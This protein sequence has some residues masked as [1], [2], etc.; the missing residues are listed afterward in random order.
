MSKRFSMT[1]AVLAVGMGLSGLV[2][3][4]MATVGYISTSGTVASGV[5]GSGL[6]GTAL[7]DLA[8]ASYVAQFK[9]DTALGIVSVGPFDSSVYGGAWNGTPTP[10]LGA[11]ITIGQHVFAL[12][13]ADVGSFYQYRSGG[14]GISQAEVD[15]GAFSLFTEFSGR[16]GTSPGSFDNPFTL[17]SADNVVIGSFSAGGTRLQLAPDSYSFSFTD[18]MAV[19]EPASIALLGLGLAGVGTLR[20]KL[21]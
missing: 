4:A 1:A 6:F 17:S 15:D 9:F 13:G 2:S 16:P 18:P 11:S 7:T 10:S 14:T 19:P 3:P 12:P 21:S 8:G 5:D 20:R